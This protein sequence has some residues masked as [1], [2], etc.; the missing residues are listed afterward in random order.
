MSE[1]PAG[2]LLCFGRPHTFHQNLS[3]FRTPVFSSVCVCMLRSLFL[4]CAAKYFSVKS[5]N[6]A[7]STKTG[8]IHLRNE[9]N[10]KSTSSE[11]ERKMLYGN[12]LLVYL[13]IHTG[14]YLFPERKTE[15][16]ENK[17]EQDEKAFCVLVNR[18]SF[19]VAFFWNTRC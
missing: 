6:I 2:L 18:P 9:H 5:E 16:A 11:N 17:A 19:V 15:G 4:L 12:A 13:R 1:L 3:F 7:S 8:G 10:T 14:P